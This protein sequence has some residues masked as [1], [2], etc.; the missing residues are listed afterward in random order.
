[1]KRIQHLLTNFFRRLLFLVRVDGESMWPVL[2]P[3]RRYLASRFGVLRVGDLAV[4]RNP[5]ENEKIFV[6]K[7]REVLAYSYIMESTVS[8]GL[9]SRDVGPVRRELILGK[10]YVR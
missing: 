1:M 8:W 4:F 7:I 9:S 2:V 5:K 3:G 6:K 10:I